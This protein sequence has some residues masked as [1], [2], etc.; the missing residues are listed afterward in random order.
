MGRLEQSGPQHLAVLAVRLYLQL[1]M[2]CFLQTFQLVRAQFQRATLTPHQSTALGLQGALLVQP[3]FPWQ[4][5]SRS[6]LE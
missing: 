5:A 2:P 6:F 4:A 1:R 3:P